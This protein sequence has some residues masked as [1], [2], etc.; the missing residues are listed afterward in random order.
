M[1][2]LGPGVIDEVDVAPRDRDILLVDRGAETGDDAGDIGEVLFGVISDTK[3]F[4]L[5]RLL[6]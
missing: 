2:A 6:R 5:R 4:F 3:F 1:A